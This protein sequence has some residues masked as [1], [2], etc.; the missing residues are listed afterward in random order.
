MNE[1]K[2][3][4]GIATL[5]N[6]SENIPILVSLTTIE[7][8][9][10]PKPNENVLL[11]KSQ[12]QRKV[13]GGVMNMFVWSAQNNELIWQGVVPT[14]ITKSIVINPDKKEVKFDN[15]PLPKNFTPVTEYYAPGMKIKGKFGWKIWLL[16]LIVIVLLFILYYYVL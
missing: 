6:E 13:D 11:P 4:I 1:N 7:N 10:K 15:T 8:A 3:P 9:T 2:G 16:F 12:T 5:V 14:K